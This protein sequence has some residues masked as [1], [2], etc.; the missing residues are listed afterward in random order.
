MVNML[1]SGR[2][3]TVPA[4]AN[5]LL[6]MVTDQPS[7]PGIAMAKSYNGTTYVFAMSDRRSSTGA[8]FTITLAGAAGR[9]ARIVFDSNA[10]YDPA[11]DRTGKKLKLSILGGLTDAFGVGGND[12]QVKAYEIQ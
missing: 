8:H 9:T 6:A 5:G 2:I 7:V 12:Y 1:P 4:C 11:H 3:V 10:K